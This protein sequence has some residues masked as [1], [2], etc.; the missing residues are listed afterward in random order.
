MNTVLRKVY[1]ALHVSHQLWGISS[2]LWYTLGS[3]DMYEEHL[4]CVLC[5]R[6]RNF[7]GKNTGVGCHFLLQGIFLT[8]ESNLCLLGLLLW[9]TDSLPLCHLASP[10]SAGSGQQ[11]KTTAFILKAE[12][13][14]FSLPYTDE[15]NMYQITWGDTIKFMG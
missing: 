7:P 10:M 3:G 13:I 2:K 8:Q 11:L 12:L 6:M 9:Q 14:F 15:L 1:D 5:V 4:S